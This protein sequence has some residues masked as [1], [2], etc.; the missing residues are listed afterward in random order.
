LS[1]LIHTDHPNSPTFLSS[2][3]QLSAY[4]FDSRHSLDC[5]PDSWSEFPALVFKCLSDEVSRDIRSATIDLLTNIFQNPP[6]FLRSQFIEKG[7]VPVLWDLTHVPLFIVP[8]LRCLTNI[9]SDSPDSRDEVLKTLF[10]AP[11]AV[12]DFACHADARLQKWIARLLSAC[13]AFPTNDAPQLVSFLEWC[14]PHVDKSLIF[15]GFTNLVSFHGPEL[16]VHNRLI[17]QF[18]ESLFEVEREPDVIVSLLHL[19]IK[20]I[21]TNS[22]PDDFDFGKVLGLL[23][24]ENTEVLSAVLRLLSNVFVSRPQVLDRCCERMASGL[25]LIDEAIRLTELPQVRA[26][27]LFLLTNLVRQGSNGAVALCIDK[28]AVAAL[29]EGLYLEEQEL[30]EAILCALAKVFDCRAILATR[31]APRDQ[32]Q[33]AGGDDAIEL[34]VGSADEDVARLA[35]LFRNHFLEQRV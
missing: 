20:L 22:I 16:I 5:D 17:I 11:Q 35:L 23:S 14:L 12:L 9:A 27:A 13:C 4:A 1:S 8:S 32:W 28:N 7:L 15:A 33:K 34:L 26:E 19:F 25:S 21:E 30:T 24:S 2:I 18:F 3:L 29:V 6:P 31:N 10:L